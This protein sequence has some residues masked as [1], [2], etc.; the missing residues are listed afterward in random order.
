MLS[1]EPT[2]TPKQRQT[3]RCGLTSS[4]IR[5]VPGTGLRVFEQCESERSHDT[6]VLGG[7]LGG[8]QKFPHEPIS[9]VAFWAVQR[10][11][12]AATG[13]GQHSKNSPANA[14]LRLKI[15][16]WGA[17]KACDPARP[18][19]AVK[20][21]TRVTLLTPPRARLGSWPKPAG[22]WPTVSTQSCSRW[23]WLQ[24]TCRSS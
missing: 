11:I 7:F 17:C 14:T 20:W 9:F 15:G 10:W 4:P 18:V 5:T 23:R 1:S 22:G 2:P 21:N 24:G 8:R 6:S 19:H 12:R 16:P 13:S 3:F